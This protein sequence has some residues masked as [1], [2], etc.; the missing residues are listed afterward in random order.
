[1]IIGVPKEIKDGEHRVAL[2]PA[3]ADAL[4]RE[5]HT[6]LV[7][8]G[9]GVDSA[10]ADA[11]FQ[12]HGAK[13]V[14]ARAA[15]DEAEMVLKVKE[16]LPAEYKRLR[17]GLL[18][19]TY[20]HLASSRELTE[21]LLDR[22]VTGVGYETVETD[23]GRLPLLAP[24]SEI[25]GKLAA[26]IG[27]HCLESTWRGRGVLLGGV[28]GVPPA[29]VV[30]LGCGTV[31][32]NAAKVAM[33]MGAQVTILDINHD[34]LKYLDDIMH[35]YVITRYSNP[36][37][38]ASC[39]SFADLIIGA[40]LIPGALA[41]KLVTEEMVK[42]MKPGAAIVD[43]A[44]DQGGCVETIHAT[45]HSEPIYVKHGVVHYGVPN[46][47]ALVPRTSTFALTN[48]TLSYALKIA[49]H[50]LEGV[51]EEDA[52]LARGINISG[53]KIFHEAVAEAFPDL[54]RT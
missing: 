3:G 2:T 37:V 30:I 6:V 17:P 43:V 8:R 38:T 16:P 14:E 36:Y 1:M 10:I 27:A 53:G 34:R 47:P 26:Q 42:E 25:A 5:G 33:G 29:D 11:E 19:F 9:A 52:A 13:L 48:A 23:D 51:A 41:P 31:G 49:A 21:E 24:M 44:V 54:P 22:G 32:L 35:G 39:A 20:L 15:W 45:S 7:E 50:G 28:P 18:L 4:T 12:A 46:M 40:V